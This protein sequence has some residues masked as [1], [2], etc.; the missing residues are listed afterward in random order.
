MIE[1]LII[2][3][4]ISW[5]F[6]LGMATISLALARQ[7]GV[8]HERIKPVGALSLAKVIKA[9][10]AAPMFSLPSLTG[11]VVTLGGTAALSQST[12]LFF[13]SPTCPVCKTLLPIL[14]SIRDDEMG[15]LQVVLASDGLEAEHLAFIKQH[16]LDDF[17]YVNST[18]VGLAYQIAKLPYGVLIG[19]DGTV[20]SHGLINSREH[21]ES[22][23]EA[24]LRGY[25]SEQ[26]LHRHAVRT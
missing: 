6:L 9:G 8:L 4:I 17:P 16:D 1:A 22:L 15:W 19:A 20:V 5:V 14:K 18:D 10:E 11:G 21:L 2:S 7:V 12:L 26:E 25:S 3:N 24:Q 23:I 13:L